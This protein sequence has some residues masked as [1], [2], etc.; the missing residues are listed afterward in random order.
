MPVS[1]K[2][3]KITIDPKL[4]KNLKPVEVKPGISIATISGKLN[5][6]NN[7]Y[8][9]LSQDDKG[10]DV[11]PSKKQRKES[12]P[13]TTQK[14]KLPNCHMYGKINVSDLLQNFQTSGISTDKVEEPG[15]GC[16]IIHL[17]I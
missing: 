2:F 1:S 11:R 17:V 5:V 9:L 3:E 15:Q 13:I 14:E 4:A 7:Q 12:S 16:C 8:K 10:S 6:L